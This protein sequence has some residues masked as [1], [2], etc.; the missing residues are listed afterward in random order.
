MIPLRSMIGI[1][2][3]DYR[4]RYEA[5]TY[6]AAD[7]AKLPYRILRPQD[8]DPQTKYPLVL[9]LHGAGERGDDN[10]K[11]L[12]HGMNDFARDE[13]RAKYPCF[14]VAPQCPKERKWVEVNWS[15][16]AHEM[17]AQPAAPLRLAMEAIA[18]LEKEFSI[19]PDR[20]YVT[21]LSMGGYGT[22]DAVARYAGRFAAA[23]PICGGGDPAQAPKIASIPLWV[24]HGAKD[25]VVKP[26]RSRQMIEAIKQAGGNPKYTEY[27]NAGHDAWS[28]TYKNPEFYAWLF[29]QR[30]PV[31]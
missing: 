28:A 24:F 27:P 23:A 9:F 15:A 2:A 18:G 19:D 16:P 4:G 1:A 11:Q 13:I 8:Y 6:E 21:G 25:G 10:V 22:W 17:P 26:E 14:V 31:R 30:R 7:G 3:D 20:I 29:A 12:I 5:R